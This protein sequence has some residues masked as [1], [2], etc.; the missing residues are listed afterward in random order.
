LALGRTFMEAVNKAARASEQGYDGIHELTMGYDGL[1]TMLTTPHP[2]K[3][4]AAYTVLKREGRRALMALAEKTA[5]DPWF[6]SQMA[7]Q[8]ELEERIGEGP[9]TEDL[10]LEAKRS[11]LS[12]KRIAFLSSRSEE[13][14]ENLRRDWSISPCF[15]F[16]DTCAGEF[17]AAT[18]Y[19]YS[20]WGEID[21]GEPAGETGVVILASG[22]NRIGQGLEFDTCCTLASLAW[23]ER[24]RRTVII[25]SNPETVSTDYNVSDR[26]YLEP[27]TAEHVKAVLAREGIRDVLVQLGGQTPLNLAK[28]LEGWG[29]RIVGTS[30]AGIDEAERIGKGRSSRFATSFPVDM[31]TPRFA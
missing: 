23:K 8:A 10:L 18:P 2:K 22:P 16:V 5:Y 17:P 20:T 13:A 14:V 12:D 7:D 30:L 27:L 9:L 26:L 31:R 1:D 24:G 11:G 3:I 25:N 28:E 19:F 29:A 15:H 21:E 4:F 6:L